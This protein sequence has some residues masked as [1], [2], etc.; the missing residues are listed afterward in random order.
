MDI[1][2]PFQSDPISVVEDS[3]I[4][5]PLASY[6]FYGTPEMSFGVPCSVADIERVAKSEAGK[7]LDRIAMHP[8][9]FA[10]L[11]PS[12]RQ[13]QFGTQTSPYFG[14]SQPS[15]T[16]KFQV[17]DSVIFIGQKS[18][19]IQCPVGTIGRVGSVTP[20][21]CANVYYFDAGPG[22]SGWCAEG[23]LLSTKVVPQK[24]QA[25]FSPLVQDIMSLLDDPRIEKLATVG[26]AAPKKCECGATKC[27]SKLHS[28][29][30]PMA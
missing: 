15:P 17:G 14:N 2:L 23:E 9:S 13:Y 28:S 4:P 8:D 25:A 30:C 26:L 5:K 20:F 11:V 10:V 6:K 18:G 7:T 1:F 19:T 16:P 27:G 22:M 21:N 29:W 3:S 24:N 12:L